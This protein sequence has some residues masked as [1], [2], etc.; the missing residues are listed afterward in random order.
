MVI[1]LTGDLV[2]HLEIVL[3]MCVVS[4]RDEKS[5]LGEDLGM[6]ASRLLIL[7]MNLGRTFWTNVHL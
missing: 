7:A 3:Q 2:A 1:V 4:L 5:R 6:D